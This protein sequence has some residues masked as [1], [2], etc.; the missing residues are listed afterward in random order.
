MKGYVDYSIYKALVE[1]PFKFEKMSAVQ[2][3]VLGFLPEIAASTVR[4]AAVAPVEGQEAAVTEVDTSKRG[5]RDVGGTDLLIKAK[6][7]TGKTL[8]F[9]IPAI[10]ARIQDLEQESRDFKEKNPDA[11][12][13]TRSRHAAS[14]AKLSVGTIILSPTRELATQIAT[15]AA[16]LLTHKKDWGV[17]LFIGGAS[18]RGQMMDF[19]RKRRDIV[20][21]TPGRMAD[22][23]KEPDLQDALRGAKVLVLDEA[24]TLL[25]M[26]FKDEL[27]GIVDQL[28]DKSVRQTFM[29]SATVSPDIKRIARSFL[30]P[31]FSFVDCVPENESNT[32]MHIPQYATILKGADEQIPHIFRLLAQDALQHPEGGKAILFFPTTKMTELFA[33]LVDGLRSELP[34]GRRGTQVFE[35]HSKKTQQARDR[36]AERFRQS[37]TGYS[38]LVTSDVSARGVDYPGVTRVIQVGI[39]TTSENYVHRLGRTGRAGKEGRGDLVLMNWEQKYLTGTLQ[40]MPIKPITAEGFKEEVEKLAEEFDANPVKAKPASTRSTGPP[41]GRGRD[42]FAVAGFNAGSIVT[43]TAPKVQGIEEKLT[44]EILPNID[45]AEVEDAF[46][47]QVGFYVGHAHELRVPKMD[48]VNNLKEWATKGFG[49]LEA[50]YLSAEFLKKIGV[51]NDRGGFRR[52]GSSRGGG[53][54][55]SRGGFSSRDSFSRGGSSGGFGGSRP[56]FSD[57][58]GDRDRNGPSRSFDGREN[59]SQSYEYIR[60]ERKS[61]NP[62]FSRDSSMGDRS[63]GGL[64]KDNRGGSRFR[65]N[66]RRDKL[67]KFGDDQ[68]FRRTPSGTGGDKY[69]F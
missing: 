12:K 64:F 41:N 6:T 20:V 39:P 30:R 65:S 14:Y 55:G 32:H 43:P 23:L 47:S 26:G 42:R 54:G 48:V 15:E 35:M 58:G 27:N 37:S 46:G 29:F 60:S 57:R 7:G 68:S 40:E 8:A 51:G 17:Q 66:D 25:D 45:Q 10:E 49:L 33:V 11:D 34:F 31:K 38:I 59:R 36:T 3:K 62:S 13:N 2:E 56:A 22:M 9:L 53:F 63:G 18:K 52:G 44:T 16:R 24:D 4:G 69:P 50:P 67:P 28:P 61:G 21:A 19:R 1:R 5:H